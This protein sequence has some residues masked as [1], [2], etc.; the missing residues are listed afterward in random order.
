MHALER[1]VAQSHYHGFGCLA[2]KGRERGERPGA[3]IEMN[4][5]I[6]A[7]HA[8]TLMEDLRRMLRTF[9]KEAL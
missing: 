5:R 1:L 9:A 6:G 2:V 3:I 4:T 8:M 7:S